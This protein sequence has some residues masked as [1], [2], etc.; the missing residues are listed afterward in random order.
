MTLGERGIN[1]MFA[2]VN[3][4]GNSVPPMFVFPRVHFKEHMLKGAPPGSKGAA[5]RSGWS[6]E[7]IFLEYLQDFSNHAKSSP[8][9]LY[10]SRC[11]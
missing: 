8:C 6:N 11:V 4:I 2:G 10:T 9:L 5:A 7:S 3:A 1:V